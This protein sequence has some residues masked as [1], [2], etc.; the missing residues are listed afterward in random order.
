MDRIA[1]TIIQNGLHHLKHNDY[2]RF[3]LDNFKYW[4][5]VEGASLNSGS[6]SWCKNFPD[7]YHN[8]GKSVD[9]TGDFLKNLASAS[10]NLIYI[11]P[12]RPWPNKDV[13]VNR[14]IEEVKKRSEKCYLWEVDID[15]QWTSEQLIGS[16]QIMHKYGAK[17][18][19]F[20]C[21]YFLGPSLLARG[22]WGEGG[23]LPYIRLWNWQGEMFETHEP[24]QLKGGNGTIVQ[25]NT[26]FNHYAMYF[27]EDVV[28]KE[29][30]YDGYDGMVER[31]EMLQNETSFPKHI[32]ELLGRK[33]HWGNTNTI[34]ERI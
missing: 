19:C 13:Q 5:V 17:T 18:G 25:I 28:F 1:F 32:S 8:N 23:I 14:C 22:G 11:E 16:E 12:D 26:K 9:G 34:I 4:I 24:P 3:M 2:Y 29:K 20:R 10:S 15:E 30:W 27:R 6:T 7:D 31:W 21:N 33:V